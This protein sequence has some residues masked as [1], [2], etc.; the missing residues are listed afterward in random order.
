MIRLV[1]RETEKNM[2][3]FYL[4]QIVP[5]L[6]GNWGL[7]REWGRIGKSGNTR[8]DWF[9]DKASAHKASDELLEDK[10]KRGYRYAKGSS[11]LA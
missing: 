6:F 2:A 11:S 9:D 10:L 5:G 4:I 7:M 1:R 3:R 8:T